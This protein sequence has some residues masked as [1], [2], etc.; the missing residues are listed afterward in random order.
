[1]H[2]IRMLMKFQSESISKF[3]E[4]MH[5]DRI[6]VYDSHER[7]SADKFKPASFLHFFT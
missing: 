2:I 1:M 3:H 5:D 4:R 6:C 7:V